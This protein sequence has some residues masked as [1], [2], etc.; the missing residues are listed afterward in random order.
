M[1][2]AVVT[3]FSIICLMSAAPGFAHGGGNVDVDV[4]TEGGETLH[5]IPHKNYETGGA[6]VF[7]KYLEA[8]KG[9]NYGIV[10]R[11]NTPDRIG[12]VIAVDGRNIING[13]ASNLRTGEAMYIVNPYSSERLDGWRTGKN[14]THQFYFTDAGDSYSARTFSDSS[15]MGVIAVAAFRERVRYGYPKERSMQKAPAPAAGAPARDEAQGLNS[16]KAGTG[17]GDERYSPTV[18]VAFE[19]EGTPFSKTLIKYEWREALCG[20]GILRCRPDDRNRLWDD[21]RYAPFP[22]GYVNR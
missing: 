5:M 2:T 19:P 17:F 21:S 13:S 8:K 12:V 22:P 1:K 15:A 16:E 4:V 6:H 11:N 3:L 7:K 18:T 20:K 10:I 9:Q 14:T